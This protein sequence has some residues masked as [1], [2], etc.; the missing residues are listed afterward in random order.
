LQASNWQDEQGEG[1][2]NL[3]TAPSVKVMKILGT[4]RVD[5]EMNQSAVLLTAVQAL[6]EYPRMAAEVAVAGY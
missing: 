1:M 3:L 4:P 6:P 2:S 5:W